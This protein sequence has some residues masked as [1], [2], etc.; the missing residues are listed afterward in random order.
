MWNTLFDHAF[1]FSM[2]FDKFKR[3]LTL[4]TTS[5]LVVSYLHHSEMHALTFDKFLHILMAS[6]LTPRVLCDDEEWLMLLRLPQHNP[7]EAQ[8]GHNRYPTWYNRSHSSPFFLFSFL[9]FLF[10]CGYQVVFNVGYQVVF[11]LRIFE[12]KFGI[13]WSRLITMITF[14][15]FYAYL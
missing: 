12:V 14:I 2:A 9:F 11:F 10:S 15:C 13:L 5:L 3:A 8:L 4:F 6:E 7:K 1:N